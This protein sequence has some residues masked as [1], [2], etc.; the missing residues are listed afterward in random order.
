MQ[1]IGSVP[2]ELWTRIR[3]ERDSETLDSW[4]LIAARAESIESFRERAEI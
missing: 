1:E 2:E 3:T 4:L